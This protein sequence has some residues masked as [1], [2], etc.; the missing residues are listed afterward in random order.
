MKI[1]FTSAH[2]DIARQ[3]LTELT[4][5][6]GQT[7]LADCDVIVA[8]GGDG[9]VMRTLFESMAIGKAVYALRRT[10]SVGFLCNDFA[11]DGLQERI[12]A[13]RSVILHPLQLE[14]IDVNG[15][16]HTALAINEVTVIRETPQ[17]ARL[18]ISVDGIERISQFSGDGIMVA[19]PAGSTAYNRSCGGPI[20]P[21]DSHSLVMT[22]ISGFLPRG[23]SHAILPE[24][25]VVG[26]EVLEVNK[27]PVRLEAGLAVIHRAI[28]AQIQ[29]DMKQQMTLLFNPD[30]HL[31][32][33][34]IRE[35]FMTR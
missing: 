2:N 9:H 10:R 27:R 8:L 12:A 13:A 35:Q 29:L 30:E 18:K 4:R 21:L 16:V 11:I 6:Y 31:G 3:A 33:R 28:Q 14:A 19:T 23:W 34:I 5:T 24:N 26:I 22:A 17:S 25:A 20:M 32:E 1:A 7:P 15:Q